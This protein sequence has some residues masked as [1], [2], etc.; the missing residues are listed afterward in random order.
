MVKI[1]HLSEEETSCNHVRVT[2]MKKAE[3]FNISCKIALNRRKFH[4]VR[5]EILSFNTCIINI[6]EMS[7]SQLA[8]AFEYLVHISFCQFSCSMCL[9]IPA[10]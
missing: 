8:N 3:N 5:W 1:R 4:S 2:V 6:I 9:P 10:L 7:K